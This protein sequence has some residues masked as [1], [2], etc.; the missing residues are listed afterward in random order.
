M[1][2]RALKERERQEQ[3]QLREQ[4]CK[5][6]KAQQQVAATNKAQRA[7][8]DARLAALKEQLKAAEEK[9]SAPCPC[10]SRPLATASASI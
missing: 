8:L 1:T 3:R 2:A 9:I 7:E 4:M 10:R 5:R 6:E